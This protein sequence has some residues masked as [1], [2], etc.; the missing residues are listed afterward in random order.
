MFLWSL[1][2]VL[3]GMILNL[4]ARH[5]PLYGSQN[6]FVRNEVSRAI[7]TGV[8]GLAIVAF[9]KTALALEANAERT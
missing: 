8:L 3:S 2:I 5:C 4:L 9:Q 7:Y 6:L 1:E